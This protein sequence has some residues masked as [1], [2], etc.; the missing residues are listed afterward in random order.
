MDSEDYFDVYCND[1]YTD[2]QEQ[3]TNIMRSYNLRPPDQFK[4]QVYEELKDHTPFEA[5]LMW[6][7]FLVREFY[8]HLKRHKWV[9]PVIHGYVEQR[10]FVESGN[11]FSFVLITRR[12][13]IFAGTRYLRRGINHEGYVA[14]W[15]EVE[16]IVYRHTNS[17]GDTLPMMSSFVQVRGSIPFFWTQ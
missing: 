9:M 14:N 13:R 10:G 15:L 4:P 16:Q 12:S 1:F 11:K 5:H 2:Q 3:P 8:S 6:N 17:L 7:Y